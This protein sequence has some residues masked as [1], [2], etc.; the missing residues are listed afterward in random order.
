MR[1]CSPLICVVFLLLPLCCHCLLQ[2]DF[3]IDE[4]LP[5]MVAWG[6]LEQAGPDSYSL[7]P[8]DQALHKL[9]THWQRMQQPTPT[10]WRA[11]DWH[12]RACDSPNGGRGGSSSSMASND[13]QEAEVSAAAGGSAVAAATRPGMSPPTAALAARQP[14]PVGVASCRVQHQL[15]RHRM[16]LLSR[17]VHRLQRSSRPLSAAA[18]GGAAGRLCL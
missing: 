11:A 6:L 5:R 8:L 14:P 13:L 9:Q 17:R 4:A 16:P 2:T 15:L 10:R 3:I 12:V 1:V 7:V 18:A